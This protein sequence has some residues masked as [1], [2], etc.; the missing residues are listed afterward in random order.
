MCVRYTP[1]PR[2]PAQRDKRLTKVWLLT[3][4]LLSTAGGQQRAQADDDRSHVSVGLGVRLMQ[5]REELIR[6]LGFA[7]PGG[8]LRGAYQRHARGWLSL[9]RVALGGDYVRERYGHGAL[10]LH[11]DLSSILA[12]RVCEQGNHVIHVGA[13]LVAQY[14]PVYYFSWDEEHLFWA[15]NYDLGPAARWDLTIDSYNRV[16]VELSVPVLGLVSRPAARRLNKVDNL[17][18]VGFWLGEPHEHLRL[19]SLH[20]YLAVR[21]RA[22]YVHQLTP[23]FSLRFEYELGYRRIAFPEPLQLLEQVLVAEAVL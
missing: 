12:H 5:T 17:T 15:L 22:Y 20:A 3:A 10:A 21:L 9:T 16:S 6:P 11:L 23:G 19:T 18:N 8:E 4:A 13:S 1:H 7:G 14:T 2:R